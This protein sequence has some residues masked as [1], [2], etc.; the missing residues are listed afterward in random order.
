MTFPLGASA[1]RSSTIR[2]SRK[3]DHGGDPVVAQCRGSPYLLPA[4]IASTAWLRSVL[5]CARVSG[6]KLRPRA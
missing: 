3:A 6:P 1:L 4:L 5:S 2:I